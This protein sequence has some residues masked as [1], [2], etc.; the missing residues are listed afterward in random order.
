MT[1]M[2]H[3]PGD[4]VIREG[5]LRRV[6]ALNPQGW[7][8]MGLGEGSRLLLL[9]REAVDVDELLTVEHQLRAAEYVLQIDSRT[10]AGT[11]FSQ[12]QPFKAGDGLYFMSN[13]KPRLKGRSDNADVWHLVQDLL[14]QLAKRWRGLFADDALRRAL[15]EA[16]LS[17]ENK[18][19]WLDYL[20]HQIVIVNRQHGV[21]FEG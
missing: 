17:T 7:S 4:V 9:R 10:A 20:H 2:I 19:A 5:L 15:L 11:G 16:G 3:K 12:Q 13:G 8:L 14:Q 21:E 1:L 6:C 18:L